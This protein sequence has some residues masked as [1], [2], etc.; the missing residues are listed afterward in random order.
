MTRS[1]ELAALIDRYALQEGVQDTILPRVTLVKAT[2]RTEP[3]HALQEA[4]VCI[5]A[6]G[7]KKVM[8][9]SDV[10]TYDTERYLIASV[11]LPLVG[12]VLEASPE[13][14]YLCFAL[15]LDPA[16]LGA[17]MLEFGIEAESPG[18]LGPG[19]SL[20]RVTPELLDAAC[21]LLRLLG[22][23]R[24]MSALAPLAEREILYRLMTGG[25]AGKLRRIAMT[26]GRLAQVNRAIGWIKKNFREPF[27]I[28]AVCEEASMSASALHAHFK[29][30]TNMSPLQYQK[31]LRLQEARRLILSRS[32]DAANA[33]HSVG[34]DSPSQFSREYRRQFGAPPLRDAERLRASPPQA[35]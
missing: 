35:G 4:A 14:P 21:R 19:I 32:T 16:L 13:A 29:S 3:L 34:Y 5:I 8:L 20:G 30:A 18:P 1:S 2:R 24:D 28:D 27:R 23:P 9:G 22:A 26:D 25:E 11:D 7:R 33:G 15:K 31:Q 17:L 10:V 12:E 6:S